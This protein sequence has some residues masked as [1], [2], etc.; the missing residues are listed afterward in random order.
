[1]RR[2]IFMVRVAGYALGLAGAGLMFHARALEGVPRERRF[3]AGGILLI[4]MFACFLAGYVLFTVAM[5][6]RRSGDRSKGDG[7]DHVSRR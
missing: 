2:V 5:F 6:R 3:L 1:M 4:A 7:H